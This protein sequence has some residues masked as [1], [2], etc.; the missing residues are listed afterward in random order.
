LASFVLGAEAKK[1]A[2][3]NCLLNLGGVLVFLPFLKSFCNSMTIFTLDPSLQVAYAHLLF[4]LITVSIFFP[5]R[6]QIIK[7]VERKSFLIS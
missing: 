2:F 4:N 6:H 1:A 3:A 7:I 5:L